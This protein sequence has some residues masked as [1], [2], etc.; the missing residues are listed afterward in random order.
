MTRVEL[1]GWFDELTMTRALTMT[2]VELRV[3]FDE[4]TMTRVELARA[5]TSSLWAFLLD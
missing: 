4:L 5:S 1:R 2:R 3:W